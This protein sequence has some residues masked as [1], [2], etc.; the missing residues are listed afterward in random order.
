MMLALVSQ[1]KLVRQQVKEFEEKLASLIE[2]HDNFS[3]IKSLPSV[4]VILISRL[5]GEIGDICKYQNADAL[6][7]QA[8][9]CPVTKRSGKHTAIVFRRGCCKPLR[10]ILFALCRP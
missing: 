8:G 4:D 3:L 7:G 9:T 10:D 2:K 5:I 1:L 6:Q